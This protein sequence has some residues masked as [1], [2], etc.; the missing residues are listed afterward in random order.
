MS[1][2]LKKQLGMAAWVAIVLISLIYAPMAIEYFAHYL[3]SDAPQLW[4]SLFAWVTSDEHVRGLGSAEYEQYQVYGASLPQMLIHTV[5]GGFAILIACIQFSARFRQRYPQ[6]HRILGRTQVVIILVLVIAA[7]FYLIR[8]GPEGTYNGPP[9]YMQLWLLAFGTLATVALAVMAILKRQV[10]VHYSFMALNFVFLLSAPFLRIEWLIFGYLNPGMRQDLTNIAS[11]IVFGALTAPIAAI[12]T[13]IMDRRPVSSV[14]K[15]ITLP[16]ALHLLVWGGGLLATI[17]I[18]FTYVEHI[19]P[20]QW[21]H[22]ILFAT[23]LTILIVYSLFTLAAFRGQSYVARQEWSMHLAALGM[24][25][26]TMLLI[27][28]GMSVFFT[29]EDAFWIA[30]FIGPAVALNV[31]FYLVAISR[32]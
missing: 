15:G 4:N 2:T 29:A 19:G 17:V 14:A 12:A 24:V 27:W 28:K 8:T 6:W 31:G 18:G 9:F 32:R 13:H 25:P 3:S 16:P 21:L 20:F 30:A 5:F 10:R 11:A 1:H 22:E 7:I 23:L 26:V